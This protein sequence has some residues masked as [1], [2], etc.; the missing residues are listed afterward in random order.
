[1]QRSSQTPVGR[2]CFKL[3]IPYPDPRKLPRAECILA[4]RGA[5]EA[6]QRLGR[7]LDYQRLL[8]R[9][10]ALAILKEWCDRVF[11]GHWAKHSGKTRWALREYPD[12]L[13]A[14][15]KELASL[16][17]SPL[18]GPSFPFTGA[19]TAD[20]S[21][22]PDRFLQWV[23]HLR[24]KLDICSTHAP[25]VDRIGKHLWQTL[26]ASLPDLITSQPTH[27]HYRDLAT[28]INATL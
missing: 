9:L 16:N 10:A 4:M 21:E 26:V 28:L 14:L 2:S 1:M 8:H 7:S 19:N 17:T 3:R 18:F 24:A 22:L 6:A 23:D 15:A 20:D 5:R 12:R 13:E 11:V 27:V 25:T